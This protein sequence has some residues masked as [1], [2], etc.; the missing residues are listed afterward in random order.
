LNENPK[1]YVIHAWIQSGQICD[2]EGVV[3]LN[4]SFQYWFE[5]FNTAKEHCSKIVRRLPFIE[6]HI[7]SADGKV[8]ESFINMQFHGTT[9]QWPRS[10]GK[11]SVRLFQMAT[12][13][14][15]LPDGSYQM[16]DQQ[17]PLLEFDSYGEAKRY[18]RSLTKS[19]PHLDYWI[20]DRTGTIMY[21]SGQR[22]RL[23]KSGGYTIP[24]PWWR[25]FL[26]SWTSRKR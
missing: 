25:V 15:L 20:Y 19:I 24:L 18:C 14:W 21:R 26:R 11:F 6:C 5:S 10:L 2:T 16:G 17:E 12:G 7:K 13:A 9:F 22:V 8:V 23:H 3:C 1:Y 4:S